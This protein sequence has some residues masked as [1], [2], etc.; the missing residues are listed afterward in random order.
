[1]P[2]ENTLPD[3]LSRWAELTYYQRFERFI[4]YVLIALIAVLMAPPILHP[5]MVTAALIVTNGLSAGNPEVFR[6][7]FARLFTVLIALE[8]K[9]TLFISLETPK[10][11]VQLRWVTAI[12]MLA[13]V[14]EVILLDVNDMTPG[15]VGALASA[16]PALGAVYWLVK[17]QDFPSRHRCPGTVEEPLKN[18]TSLE[19]AECASF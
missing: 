15:L 13:L 1:L 3:H 11:H 6:D 8:F 4:L 14:R 16:I 9:N 19:P 12:A 17:S 7:I 18:G 2:F 10:H 5:V